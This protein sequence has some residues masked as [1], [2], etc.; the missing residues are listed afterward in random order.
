MK[1][2]LL[3]TTPPSPWAIICDYVNAILSGGSNA[4]GTITL[5]NGGT[6]TTLQ[7]N[8]LT[9]QSVIF[10]SP[11]TLHASTVTGIWYDPTSIT[12]PVGGVGGSVT[13]NHSSVAQ[14]DLTFGY[15]IMN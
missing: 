4:I 2:N 8:L 13:L 1:R 5:T 15:R 14:S 11:Q 6:T 12:I 7:N 10:L 3:T 9:T